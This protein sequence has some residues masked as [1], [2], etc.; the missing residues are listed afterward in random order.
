MLE[1]ELPSKLLEK[2][3][4]EISKLPGIGRRTAL[5]L[6]LHLLTEKKQD[7]LKLGESLNNLINNIHYCKTCHNITEDEFC[8]ICTNQ[9]R[10]HETICIVEDIRDLLAIENT[11]QYRGVY[12]VLGGII[13]P[14]KGIQ[15]TDLSIPLLLERVKST[16]VK[17]VILALPTTMEGETTNYYLHKHLSAYVTQITTLARGIAMGDELQYADEVTLGRSLIE[18][19]TY[20]HN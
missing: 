20:S 17:E 5:R 14:A 19:I 11:Q 12:H 4:R 13:M 1:F 18:R 6:A 3:V 16:S 9:N 8:S 7:A 15:P 10:D 2:A